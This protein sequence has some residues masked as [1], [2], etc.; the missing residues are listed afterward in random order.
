MI[1]TLPAAV[2]LIAAAAIA[3]LAPALRASRI[4]I[5]NALRFRVASWK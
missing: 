3:S 1:P 4:D 5:I 2:L